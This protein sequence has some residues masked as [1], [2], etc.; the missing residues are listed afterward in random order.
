MSFCDQFCINSNDRT[1]GTNASAVYFTD[2]RFG[3]VYVVDLDAANGYSR[4]G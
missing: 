2:D 4:I 1:G 3:G